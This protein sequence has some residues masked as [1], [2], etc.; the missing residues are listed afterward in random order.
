M[1]CGKLDDDLLYLAKRFGC[2]YTRYAD[3]ISFS[4][5]RLIFPTAI[6]RPEYD[7]QTG[8]TLWKSG[9]ELLERIES[10]GFKINP[11]KVRMQ[12]INQHQEV[13]GLTANEFPNVKRRYV[14]QIRAMLHA[15]EKYGLAAAH[16]D[17][18]EQ[19]NQKRRGPHKSQP[20]F[21]QVVKGKIE[22][23]GMVRG[24]DNSLYQ[25][26]LKKY[27]ELAASRPVPDRY[28]SQPSL[29]GPIPESR[30]FVLSQWVET[31]PFPLA[32]ILRH[33]D[34][35]DDEREKYE[36]LL[37]FFEGFALF[38]ATIL[39][40]GF[41]QDSDM[42]DSGWEKVSRALAERHD[43]MRPTFG[44]WVK[45]V[46]ALS[47]S[48]RKKVRQEE[49]QE[50]FTRLFKSGDNQTAGLLTSNKLVQEVLVPANI[51]RNRKAHGGVLSMKEAAQR[52]EACR[53]LLNIVIE[54]FAQKWD[55]YR[56]ILPLD[57]EY[58]SGLFDYRIKLVTGSNPPFKIA[59]QK[60]EKP[61]ERNKPHFAAPD[62]R[63]ALMLLPMFHLT[64]PG[65][66]QPACYFYNRQE[67]DGMVRWISYH[68]DEQAER[69]EKFPE[70]LAECL[71]RLTN[72]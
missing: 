49:D 68:F 57:N 5:S 2:R 19:Y 58:Q 30:E 50:L 64:P 20:S 62:N 11:D 63:Q 24:H 42:R 56:L 16:R 4:T 54:E 65:T 17:Y 51:L 55:G 29:N 46:E 38:W 32:S 59:R 34:A 70:E 12:F 61:L 53:K 37:H 26:F 69:V 6:A 67:S 28:P 39:L 41:H 27:K 52:H 60:F 18:Y 71:R 8:K 44:T 47:G 1:I 45:I 36:H 15:W 14:R 35:T 31:L 23:L 48:L 7:R 22:F 43:M 21:K 66:N 9:A 25:N 3:D 40:S 33:Y 72:L 13:T 10:Q